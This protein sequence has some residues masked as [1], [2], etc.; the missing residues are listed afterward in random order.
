M[1]KLEEANAQARL[2][3]KNSRGEVGEMI[4]RVKQEKNTAS[5]RMTEHP[6]EWTEEERTARHTMARARMIA[7]WKKIRQEMK[8]EKMPGGSLFSI[9][10]PT[11]RHLEWANNLIT[12]RRKKNEKDASQKRARAWKR[13]M[14]AA[15]GP[16]ASKEERATLAKI[17]R[18]ARPDPIVQ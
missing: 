3:M 4:T 14:A 7:R 2:D 18:T 17:M 13:R 1:F 6:E 12:A 8:A 16:N 9:V 11:E 15:T 5:I 10:I